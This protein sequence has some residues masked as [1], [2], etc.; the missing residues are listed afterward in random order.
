M[1]LPSK[2]C[3]KL[4]LHLIDSLRNL[5]YVVNLPVN[6]R[7]CIMLFDILG[8][9]LKLLMIHKADATDHTPRPDIQPKYHMIGIFSALFHQHA[10]VIL[11]KIPLL[12]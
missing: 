5:G 7:S 12:S 6:H 4:Q 9:H 3:L 2:H 1:K 10:S 8:C 11:Y